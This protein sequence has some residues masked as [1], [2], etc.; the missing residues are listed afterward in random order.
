MFLVVLKYVQPLHLIDEALEDHRAFLDR[1][2]AAGH[3]LA[4]GPLVP[5]TGGVILA[6]GLSRKALEDVLAEDPFAQ[7]QLAEYQICEFHPVRAVEGAEIL[8]R[9]LGTS[10]P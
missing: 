9:P 4:S 7:A 8:L 5:R 1:Q 3:F 6:T 10:T 2:Y